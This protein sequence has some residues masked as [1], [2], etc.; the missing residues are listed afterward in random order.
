MKK[1]F[2]K[3]IGGMSPCCREMAFLASQSLDR[4]LTF[5]EQFSMRMHGWICSWCVDYSDQV[6]KVNDTVA[7]EGESLAEMKDEKLS[8]ACKERIKAMI[9]SSSGND[10][11]SCL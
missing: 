1:L 6:S 2:T 9:E 10:T 7:G 11:P 8:E 4:R 5:R 3:V